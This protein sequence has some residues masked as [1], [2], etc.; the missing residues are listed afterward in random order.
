MYISTYVWPKCVLSCLI[1]V[2]V[3]QRECKHIQ[4]SLVPKPVLNLFLSRLKMDRRSTAEKG[5]GITSNGTRSSG[6]CSVK[7]ADY[8]SGEMDWERVD[9]RLASTL[10]QFQREGVQ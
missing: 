9:P 2:D 6:L 3:V 10:M 1:A 5:S 7:G 4:L 8:C